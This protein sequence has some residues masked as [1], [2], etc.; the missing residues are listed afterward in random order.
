MNSKRVEPNSNIQALKKK[1]YWRSVGGDV[2]K[3]HRMIVWRTN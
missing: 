2:I 3:F 1:K